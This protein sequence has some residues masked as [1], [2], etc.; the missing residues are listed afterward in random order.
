MHDLIMRVLH[1]IESLPTL[2][3]PEFEKLKSELDALILGH[4]Y[5]GRNQIDHDAINA[6][7]RE[8][9]NITL[10]RM[11]S[12]YTITTKKGLIAYE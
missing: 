6:L 1:D 10:T 11:W 3:G 5:L 4:I 12:K 7:A 2:S 8:G 9:H